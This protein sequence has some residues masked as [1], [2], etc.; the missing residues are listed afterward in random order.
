MEQ[1]QRHKRS[2]GKI[3]P[4]LDTRL[5]MAMT[6]RK[7]DLARLEQVESRKFGLESV[8][9]A[10][11]DVKM[12][13]AQIDTMKATNK[14]LKQQYGKINIDKI[15]SLQDEMADLMDVGREINDSLANA[16][17]VPQDVDEEE[18]DAELDALGDEM[19][20]ER[21]LGI[22]ETPGFLQ[23]E[24]PT[25][26]DAPPEQSKVQEPAGGLG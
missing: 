4:V 1:Y 22:G 13:M 14:A 24:V 11:D 12:T 9:T 26:I 25:F 5:R 18:L 2:G 15:E 23:D 19:L 10:S 21:E 16:Y 8:K 20:H 7:R 17:G 3:P 6:R